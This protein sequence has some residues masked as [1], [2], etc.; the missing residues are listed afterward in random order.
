M[1]PKVLRPE[2]AVAGPILDGDGGTGPVLVIKEARQARD[3]RARGRCLVG[4]EFLSEL[5]LQH[6]DALLGEPRD[7]P[8]NVKS[9][10]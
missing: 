4:A 9:T 2:P 10:R 1:H 3:L 7:T 5:L 6:L 8:Q